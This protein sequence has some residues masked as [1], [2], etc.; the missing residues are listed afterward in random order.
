M[1]D[2]LQTTVNAEEGRR[3][4]NANIFV[5]SCFHEVLH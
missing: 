5:P 4:S 3:H 1:D 2:L